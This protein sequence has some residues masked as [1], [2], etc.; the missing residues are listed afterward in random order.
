MLAGASVSATIITETEAFVMHYSPLRYPGGKGSLAQYVGNLMEINGLVGG[1][2]VEPYAG[3]GGLAI[4][5]MYLE[6]AS[7]IHLND[8][9]R[10]IFSFW[11]ALKNEPENLCRLVRDTPI[12][13]DEWKRQKAVQAAAEPHALDLGFST[14]FLNRTNVSGIINGGMI[15]GKNQSGDWKLDARFNRNELVRRIEKLASYAPRITVYNLDAVVFLKKCLRN[16]P[17]AALVYLD[18]PYYVRG[19][20]LYEN[21]YEYNDHAKISKTV[22]SIKQKWIV[23]YDNVEP[24]RSLYSEYRQ[25]VF[26]IRYTARDSRNGTEVMIFGPATKAPGEVELWRGMAT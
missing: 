19:M 18:P 10:S 12:T 7:H 11:Q 9:N 17:K 2:Y 21:H 14:F 23:S 22:G 3:G 16:I 6:Y 24:I 26:D 15:G 25:Q 8:L 4:T 5:L 20:R 1:H 13:A